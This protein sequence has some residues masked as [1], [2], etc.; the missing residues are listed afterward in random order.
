MAVASAPVSFTA[1]LTF[2]NTGRSRCVVPAFFGFVPPTTFVP[3]VVINI[4]GL[5]TVFHK[6]ALPYAIACSAWKLVKAR[7]V[8]LCEFPNRTERIIFLRGYEVYNLRSLFSSK[9]LIDD[10]C[11]TINAEILDSGS[12]GRARSDVSTSWACSLLQSRESFTSE[13]LHGC[14]DHFKEGGELEENGR[15]KE[16]DRLG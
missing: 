13:G 14:N 5:C 9:P 7:G 3:V 1:S 8:S 4:G 12:I 10:L 16:K 6:E 15:E 2:A 11:V